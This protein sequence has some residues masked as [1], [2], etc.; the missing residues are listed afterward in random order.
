MLSL[1]PQFF[2][3]GLLTGSVYALIAVSIVL[4]YKSTRIFNFAVGEL[5]A[6]GGYFCYSFVVWFHFPLWLA[7]VGALLMAVVTGLLVERLVLRPLLGQPLL[8][9]IMATLAL[10]VLLRGIMLMIWTGYDVAFP[11]NLLPGKTVVVGSVAMSAELLWAFGIAVVAFATLA[12][13]FVKTQTGLRM[14]AVSQDH[15]LAM[16]CGINITVVF[17]LTWVLAVI[18]GT[19]AGSLMGYRLALAPS[20]TPLLALKAFPAVIF[21]GL[22]SVTGALLGGLIVGI[23]ESMVGGLIDPTMGE[24]SAYILLLA[25][26]LIRPEGLMGL[27][28][29]ERV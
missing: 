19:L 9:I 15:E 3:S 4:V 28:R 20:Y 7:L 27:K 13:F 10:S 6:L 18:L 11:K 2:V 26:L 29:I 24:I 1:V 8:T 14:R 5:L 17:A 16:S 12:Y 21:G 25:V 23:I 22:D